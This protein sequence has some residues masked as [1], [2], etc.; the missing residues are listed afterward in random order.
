[1]PRSIGLDVGGTTIKAGLVDD[2]NDELESVILTQL[3]NTEAASL[4]LDQQGYI[5]QEVTNKLKQFN[6]DEQTQL[7]TALKNQQKDRF[8]NQRLLSSLLFFVPFQEFSSRFE[9]PSSSQVG[10]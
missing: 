3:V 9:V 1:M 8:V 7:E 6:E 2:V 10:C 4:K 5:A